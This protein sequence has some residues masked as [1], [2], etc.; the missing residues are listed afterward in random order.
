MK[1][2]YI[3]FGA[4][5]F[6]GLSAAAFAQNPPPIEWVRQ[7]CSNNTT[8]VN[9]VSV[10]PSGLYVAGVTYGTFPEQTSAG[11]ADIF[12]RKY[13]TNGTELWT[14][15]FGTSQNDLVYGIS[16]DSTG[17]YVAGITLGTFPGQTSAG[18]ADG[19]VRKYDTNGTELWTRQFGTS[20]NDYAEGMSVDSTGIYVAGVTC[21]TF[22][23][24]TSAG[25][26]DGF[27]RKYDTNGTEGWTRQFGT[28]A[29][30]VVYGISVDS[31][32]IYVDGITPGT[33]PG[34]TSAGG[35]DAFV[36]KYD[37][38][39]TQVWTRQFGTSQNDYAEGI[40]VDSTG[41]YVAG[42]TLGTFPGQTSAGGADGFVR[43]YDTSG[44]ELWTR[45]FGT[46]DP[47][48]VY[49]IS[50]DSTGIYVAGGTWGTF[51]GQTK[52]CEVDAFV[53]KLRFNA[54]PVA[55]AGPDQVIEATGQST[56]FALNGTNSSDPDGDV[57]IYS[58]KDGNG[59]IVG[60]ESIVPLSRALGTYAFTL[61][62]TDPDGLNS[63][64]T[65][66]VT[67]RDTTPP[68][69]AALADLTLDQS[70]PYG[71]AVNLSQPTI[72]DAC[73]PSPSVQNNAPPLFPLG[74]TIITWTA[75]DDSGNVAT[76]QQKVTVVPGSPANQLANLAKLIQY[77]V[78]SGGIDPELETSLLAKV[79][80]ASQALAKA[81]KSAAMVAMSDLS[82]LVNQVEAQADKK[83][84]PEIAA[85]II[86]WANQVITAL[87]G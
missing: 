65:V 53:V 46:Y 70:D 34:Q 51:P 55:N 73:D 12:V 84:T 3:V 56:Y 49:G 29:W 18:G 67:I 14:R 80:A 60:T 50:V 31:T 85:Q 9:A 23:E 59:N 71:T 47:D 33:F 11:G 82:A 17:I 77:S 61:T 58:W 28:Y 42:H 37:T 41:I 68:T 21:G 74:E 2:F 86:A 32:G 72:T 20:Q 43:K 45:Q 15:Q 36:R 30:D 26:A 79:A 44:T 40:S 57:I 81:N 39:G 1:R 69:I 83:I 10:D 27:V 75:T 19:F 66:S 87:G 6:L 64:D 76:T 62:V 38:N 35:Q 48:A 63:S 5:V 16:V 7:F 54:P 24:Q 8:H 25:G 13:D 22:P 78:A 4:M 52:G